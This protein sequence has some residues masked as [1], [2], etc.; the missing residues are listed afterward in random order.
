MATVSITYSDISEQSALNGDFCDTG[1][2]THGGW[3]HSMRH[4]ETARDIEDHP[5]FY[6]L[7]I[8]NGS[9]AQAIRDARDLGIQ[10]REGDDTWVAQSTDPDPVTGV[11][12]NLTLHVTGATQ[13]T[14]DRIDAALTA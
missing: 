1:F 9:L 4:E 8:G 2:W 14:L 13:A 7:P 12:T 10:Y 5:E 11:Y 6:W 3:K